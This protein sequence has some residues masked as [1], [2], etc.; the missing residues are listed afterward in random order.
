MLPLHSEVKQYQ[1]WHER[2]CYDSRANESE[3]C[4]A[5]GRRHVGRIKSQRA[6]R[7][8]ARLGAE[9]DSTVLC[10][11]K[12]IS[13]AYRP[14]QSH[15]LDQAQQ[16]VS[17]LHTII[18]QLP[19]TTRP[20][21]VDHGHFWR[22]GYTI[23]ERLFEPGEIEALRKES[24][25][26][27]DELARRDL[28]ITEQGPEGSARFTR[29]DVLSI[30]DIRHI[31]LDPRLITAMHQLLGSRP[32]YFGESVLRVGTRGGRMWH[33]D[34]VDRAKQHGGPDWH[35]PYTIIRCG[36]YMQDHTRH[37]GGLAVR[38]RSNRPG[39]Q[40]RSIPV[41]INVKPGDLVVWDLR[42]VHS[43]E[44]IRLRHA[45]AMPVHPYL[46]PRVPQKLRLNDERERMVIFITFGLPGVHLDR[47]IANSKARRENRELW[48]MSRF[49][50]DV[51]QQ[52]RAVGLDILAVTPEYGTLLPPQP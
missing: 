38:P 12:L 11:M 17:F 8:N 52:A 4:R 46:Q 41:F 43:G 9:K 51:W 27:M 3:T 36:L 25:R 6:S 31:L 15:C 23:I 18:D 32:T 20:T 14:S 26:A 24:K 50:E 35:D 34:N 19:S 16:G 13:G 21:V 39:W 47:Y 1:A 40:I 29:C 28:L 2:D 33:R 44:V 45:P 30:S 7:P 49:G 42:T 5:C 37:S 22:R 10:V 48:A